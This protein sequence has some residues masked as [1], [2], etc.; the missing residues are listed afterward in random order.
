MSDSTPTF[1]ALW[2]EMRERVLGLAWQMCGNAADAEDA[3][4]E[5][6]LKVHGALPAFRG[7]SQATTWVWRIAIREASRVRD[8][9]RASPVESFAEGEEAQLVDRVYPDGPVGEEEARL[10]REAVANLPVAHSA[11]LSLLALDGL[12]AEEVA[13]ILGIPEG[14][15]WSRASKARRLLRERLT[16]SKW[17]GDAL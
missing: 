5:T 17:V 15:V 4:Q 13:E 11:V 10:V 1:D 16:G 9:R 14:T 3:L 12:A 6:F 7:E 8:K 2:S